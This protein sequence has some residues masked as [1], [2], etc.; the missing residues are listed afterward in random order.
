MAG[1]IDKAKGRMKKVAGE[2]TDSKKLKNEGTIDKLSGMIKSGVE[3]IRKA[4]LG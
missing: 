3:R 2:L 4:L 1:E